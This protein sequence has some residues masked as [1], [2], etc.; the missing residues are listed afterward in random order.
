[1]WLRRWWPWGLV[2]RP[3]A[4][5]TW[6]SFLGTRDKSGSY[7][8]GWWD[9]TSD[10]KSNLIFL[11]NLRTV[12]NNDRSS[13]FERKYKIKNVVSLKKISLFLSE[14]NRNRIKVGFKGKERDLKP[15]AA[16][17]TDLPWLISTREKGEDSEHFWN[18]RNLLVF[19]ERKHS[20][21]I[22]MIGG[23]QVCVNQLR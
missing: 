8:W 17:C 14:R 4:L 3:K 15:N 1:M 13:S 20:L 11:C 2:F 16:V 5:L 9:V 21:K 23:F 19:P 22:F 18:T 12:E 6:K 7:G 10:S